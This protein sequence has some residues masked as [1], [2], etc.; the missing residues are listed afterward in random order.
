MSKFVICTWGGSADFELEKEVED[1]AARYFDVS[2]GFDEAISFSKAHSDY[3]VYVAA[4][5]MFDVIAR[6][7][8][9]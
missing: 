2:L 6:I 3:V 9:D 5:T 1:C 7:A 8:N 4:R